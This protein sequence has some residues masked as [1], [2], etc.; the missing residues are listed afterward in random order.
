MV[1]G[2]NGVYPPYSADTGAYWNFNLSNAGT[3]NGNWDGWCMDLGTYRG[4]LNYPCAR[5]YSSLAPFPEYLKPF[6]QGWQDMDKI[7]YLINHFVVGQT[8]QMKGVGCNDSGGTDQITV[9]DLQKVIWMILDEGP[10]F[11]PEWEALSTIG[12]R[13]AIYCDVMANGEGFVPSCLNDDLIAFI[14][15]PGLNPDQTR[16]Q[17]LFASAPCC[18]DP[19]DVT[20]WGDGKYGANFR[21]NNWATFFKWCPTCPQ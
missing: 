19:Q 21:G 13:N 16:A 20:A 11:Q 15:D 2:F 7:N 6:V 9:V 12:V 8:V 5:I 17:P 1:H 3:F 14:I 10:G 4:Q 18:D